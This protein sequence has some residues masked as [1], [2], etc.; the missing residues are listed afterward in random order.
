MMTWDLA[1]LMSWRL[2]R[3]VVPSKQWGVVRTAL[4]T[5]SIPGTAYILVI[6]SGFLITALYYLP[7]ILGEDDDKG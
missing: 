3:S 5:I 1:V 2:V 6:G 4:D 7:H